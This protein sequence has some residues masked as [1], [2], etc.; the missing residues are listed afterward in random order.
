MKCQLKITIKV[1]TKKKKKHTIKANEWAQHLIQ[2]LYSSLV[3]GLK[4]EQS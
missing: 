3:G 1:Q 2:R 4:N